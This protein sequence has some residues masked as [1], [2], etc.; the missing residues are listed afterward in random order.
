MEISSNFSMGR[1]VSSISA[2][3]PMPAATEPAAAQDMAVSNVGGGGTAVAI[4]APMPPQE[5][6]VVYDVKAS[7]PTWAADGTVYRV[8]PPAVSASLVRAISDAAG[9]PSQVSSGASE[10]QGANVSW[11][12]AAGFIWNVDMP[13]RNLNWWKNVDYSRPQDNTNTNPK[14]DAD[15]VK[16]AADNFLRDHGFG[17]LVGQGVIEENPMIMPLLRGESM[18]CIMAAEGRVAPEDAKMMIYPSPCGYPIQ[19]TVYYPDVRDGMSTVDTGG[20]M[21]RKANIQ[22]DIKDNSIVGG[23]VMLPASEDSSSYPLISSDDAMKRLMTGG[24][25]P[26]YGWYDGSG[27]AE[28]R[29]TISSVKLGWMRHDSWD[30]GMTKTYF[31][32]ALLAEG[33]V[34]RGSDQVEPEKYYTVVPLVAD[35][36]FQTNSSPIMYLKGGADPAPAP[37][38]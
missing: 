24:N 31:L 1:T 18:P 5:T 14:I 3:A 33:T 16:A 10:V 7:M 15:A 36:A 4:R 37:K 29:A 2:V 19:V 25:N 30:N 34:D 6:K 23:N 12:D 11:R 13:G 35:A 21:S 20:W 38:Q 17:H 9:V 22:I 27:T 32:P 8:R 26:V 28:V